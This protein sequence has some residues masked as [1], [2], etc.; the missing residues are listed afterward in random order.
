MVWRETF[1]CPPKTVNAPRPLDADFATASCSRA[2][3][4]RDDLSMYV[5]FLDGGRPVDVV[6]TL[7]AAMGRTGGLC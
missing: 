7:D 5:F 4:V 1:S 3:A 2:R 6:Q